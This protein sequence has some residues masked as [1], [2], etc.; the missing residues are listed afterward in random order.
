MS[1][2]TPALIL[3]AVW[4]AGE[5]PYPG[6]PPA[7]RG[8]LRGTQKKGDENVTGVEEFLTLRTLGREARRGYRDLVSKGQTGK[9]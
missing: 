3:A 1:Y 9:K 6:W 8:R 2:N 4:N 5:K 7:A